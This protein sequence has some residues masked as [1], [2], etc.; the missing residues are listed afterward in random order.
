MTVILQKISPGL[1][2]FFITGKPFYLSREF[3]ALIL[4]GVYLRPGPQVKEV[5]RMLADQILSVERA[6]LDSLVIKLDFNKG[7]PSHE[8]LKYRQFIKFQ[9]R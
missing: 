4:V 6:N 7:N 5:Q 1:E 9:R 8:L 3:A 2:S